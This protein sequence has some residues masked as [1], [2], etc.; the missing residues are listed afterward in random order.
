VILAASFFV[1]GVSYILG[2][3]PIAYATVRY[4]THVVRLASDFQPNRPTASVD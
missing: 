4:G 2:I 3:Y 1:D